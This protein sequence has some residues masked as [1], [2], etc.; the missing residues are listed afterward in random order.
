MKCILHTKKVMKLITSLI[1]SFGLTFLP[2]LILQL[3]LKTKQEKR[4]FYTPVYYVN[5]TIKLDINTPNI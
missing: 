4:S 2:S 3:F 1:L 5:F